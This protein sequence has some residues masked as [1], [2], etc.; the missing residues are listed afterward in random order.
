M[1][2]FRVSLI[3]V[4]EF[5]KWLRKSGQ[6]RVEKV[7][8]KYLNEACAEM[9]TD[10]RA[11]L[12]TYQ[13]ARGPFAAWAPLAPTTLLSKKADT[14]LLEDMELEESVQYLDLGPFKKM[15]GATKPGANWHEYGL[16]LRDPPLPARP[17]V[18]PVVWLKVD[19][20]RMGLRRAL[21]KDLRES[22][23][24]AR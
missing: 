6:L 19:S 17:F 21:I 14:P 5:S 18:R 22:G 12:G 7:T 11:S 8:N 4:N 1:N 3:N 24:F 16:P 20:M 9:V 15:V 2:R 10:I 23:P 13:P